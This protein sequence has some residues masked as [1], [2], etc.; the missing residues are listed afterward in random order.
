M[1]LREQIGILNQ[2]LEKKEIDL[3]LLSIQLRAI[4]YY[5]FYNL[6]NFLERRQKLQQQIDFLKKEIKWILV[7]IQYKEEEY[8]RIRSMIHSKPNYIYY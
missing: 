4:S 7:Q 3:E 1:S 8:K 5:Y 2:L 6:T